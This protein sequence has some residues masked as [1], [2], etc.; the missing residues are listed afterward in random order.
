MMHDHVARYR[1][2]SISGAKREIAIGA[3][4]LI[5]RL[6]DLDQIGRF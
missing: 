1:S 5:S 2:R 4:A 3:S 6:G